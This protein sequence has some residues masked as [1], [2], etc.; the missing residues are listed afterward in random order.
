MSKTG[1]SFVNGIEDQLCTHPM[2]GYR[3]FI[4]PKEVFRRLSLTVRQYPFMLLGGEGH[5]ENKVSC[6]RTE[7]TD[8]VTRPGLEPGKW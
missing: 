5:G 6:L 3:G 2:E 7:H 4:C 1:K 8:T